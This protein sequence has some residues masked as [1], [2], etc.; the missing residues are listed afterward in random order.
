MIIFNDGHGHDDDHGR[1]DSHGH[2]GHSP[3]ACRTHD[4]HDDG[5]RERL[6]RPRK[7]QEHHQ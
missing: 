7:Q 2:D 6:G 1:D 3:D 4:A 5:C